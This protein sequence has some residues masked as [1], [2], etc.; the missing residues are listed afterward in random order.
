[1]SA[2]RNT[3]S[4]VTLPA[5]GKPPASDKFQLIPNVEPVAGYVLNELLGRGGFGEVWKATGPGGLPVAMKF[6]PLEEGGGK[7]ELRSLEL[8]KNI[9]HPHLL[10]VFGAW[11]CHGYVVLAMELAERT[12]LQRHREAVRQ[13]LQGIPLCELLEYIREAAKGIDYLNSVGVQHRDIKPHNLFLVGGSVKV[14]DFGLA[15]ALKHTVADHTGAMTPAYAP[16]EF[17][18]GETT[19]F[20]DQYALA[21]TYCQLRTGQLP[22][23]GG[24]AVEV[25]NN[26]LE[27]PPNLAML[28]EAERP[29]LARALAKTPTDRWGTCR[30]FTEALTA[31][32]PEADRLPPLPVGSAAT[33]STSPPSSVVRQ[34]TATARTQLTRRRFVNAVGYGLG[35][36]LIAGYAEWK[37]DYLGWFEPPLMPQ[38]ASFSDHQGEVTSVAFTKVGRLLAGC[39]DRTVWLWNITDGQ[40][41]V[42][43]K[44]HSGRVTCVAASP[45]G[46]HAASASSDESVR[47]WDVDTGKETWSL[48]VNADITSVAFS[49][50]GQKLAFGA[51]DGN[52]RLCNAL[53]KKDLTVHLAHGEI[54][55][56]GDKTVWA[57]AF[58]A[59]REF[60]LASRG[61]TVG[62]WKLEKEMKRV[63]FHPAGPPP[64]GETVVPLAASSDNHH[65]LIGQGA[66]VRHCN[67]ADGAPRFSMKGHAKRVTAVAYTPDGR[68]A[69]SASDDKTI[70]L[71]DLETGKAIGRFTA[72]TAAVLSVAVS[73]DGRFAA[74]GGADRT[75]RIIQ[76][77]P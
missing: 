35:A 10:A 67:L 54:A 39:A 24:T 37:F 31:A 5:A 56:V 69:L 28:T 62:K 59:D 49:P 1:M 64:F 19:Q 44:Q 21:V 60:V 42:V 27:K 76:L 71:W 36:L 12:L 14:A 73:P 8:L 30:A 20:S 58:T 65:F 57:V 63:F 38:V 68:R 55:Y 40:G 70:R 33:I 26:V 75:V 46:K 50:D 51:N 23:G 66:V 72:H 61:L 11:Q 9:R 22:F 77:P 53:T 2:E 34:K 47:L 32:A 25:M 7:L 52:L 41:R 29:V 16:P 13:G 74:S 45:D 48:G 43:F 6:V 3:S 17:F 18:R 15:K 4:A